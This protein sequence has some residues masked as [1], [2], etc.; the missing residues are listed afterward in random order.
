MTP[1]SLSETGCQAHC[2]TRDMELLSVGTGH[3]PEVRD[4]TIRFIR[5][6]SRQAFARDSCTLIRRCRQR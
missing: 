6:A 5:Y 4:H 1:R 3:I 2:D